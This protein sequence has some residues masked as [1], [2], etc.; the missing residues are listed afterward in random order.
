M[1]SGLGH[2]GMNEV[3][4]FFKILDKILLESLGKE[5]SHFES[6]KAYNYFLDCKVTHKAWQTFEILLHGTIMEIIKLYLDVTS[7]Q[8]S[9]IDFLRWQANATNPNLKLLT[10]LFLTFELAIYIQRIGDRNNDAKMSNAGR[11]KF[12]YL[13]FAFKHP[14]YREVEYWELH[15]KVSYP[16][17]IQVLLESNVSYS[18]SDKEQTC[19]GA[20]FILE[21]KVKNQK[22]IAPKG[23]VSVKIW[24]RISRSVDKVKSLDKKAKWFLNLNREI[25]SRKMLLEN[26][27]IEWRALLRL[28]NYIT[29]S[30][31]NRLTNIYGEPLHED[32]RNLSGN[33]KKKSNAMFFCCN[34]C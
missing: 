13:F 6:Q 28:S 34:E 23:I 10:Q 4:T 27:T 1:L 30:E 14:I 9:V 18:S 25:T 21:E 31:S 5:V 17:E 33:A 2:L 16:P 8:V 24:Q 12:F 32:M 20:D 3:K 11:Y 22:S 26:E 7:S 15:N 29:D 19:Q